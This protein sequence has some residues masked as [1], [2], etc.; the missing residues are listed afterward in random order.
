MGGIGAVHSVGH[1]EGV[2]GNWG[3]AGRCCL[4]AVG[5]GNAITGMTDAD[6][7]S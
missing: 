7:A 2:M 6:L 3:E 1:F 5:V 4:A